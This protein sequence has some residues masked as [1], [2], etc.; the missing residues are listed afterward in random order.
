MSILIPEQELSQDLAPEHAVEAAY[1]EDLAKVASDLQ[2][3]LPVLVEC[4]KDLAPFLFMNVRARL[5]Q[6]DI[7]CLYLDGRPREGENAD[8]MAGMVGT[9]IA[10]L[11]D[12]VRG[13]V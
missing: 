3:G 11:R 2:R 10:Q 12:A 6:E 9:M 1:A 7:R 4:D 8:P 13:A 5:R